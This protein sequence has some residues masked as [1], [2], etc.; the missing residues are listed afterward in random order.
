[1]TDGY[2]V[3]GLT[4]SNDGDIKGYHVPTYIGADFLAIKV[5]FN[6]NKLWARAYGGTNDEVATCITTLGDDYVLA[7]YATS[8]DGD[9][10]GVHGAAL[11]DDAWVVKLN[12][13][14]DIGWQKTFG[15][16]NIDAAIAIAPTPDGGLI[17]GGSTFSNDGDVSGFHKGDWGDGWIVKMDAAG[18]KQ[19]TKT[20]GGSDDEQISG[21]TVSGYGYFVSGITASTDGDVGGRNHGNYDLWVMKLNVE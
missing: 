9:V 14:G 17:L 19:W 16:R 6:G 5:D 7:G 2:V 12:K 21:I 11:F 20:L 4:F 18:N 1:T 8:N 3:A 15:G 10:T 13:N